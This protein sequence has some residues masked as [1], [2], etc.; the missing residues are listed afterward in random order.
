[1]LLEDKVHSL[2]N[3]INRVSSGLN[4]IP[5]E[6]VRKIH[7]DMD[8]EKEIKQENLK[9]TK[10]EL[11]ILKCLCD[12]SSEHEISQIVK[13]EIGAIQKTKNTLIDRTK[14]DNTVNL[15]LYAIQNQL[16]AT[17]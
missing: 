11:K 7:Y 12:G 3:A 8:S 13:K 6:M 15:I 10:I 9:F 16:V 5:V 1:M 14:T 4:H 17:V 2:I